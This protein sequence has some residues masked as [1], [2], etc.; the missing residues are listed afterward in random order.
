[1]KQIAL[2]NKLHTETTYLVQNRIRTRN[3]FV[4]TQF[5]QRDKNSLGGE[6]R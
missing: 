1:M 2:P 3:P 6:E 4:V 5:G